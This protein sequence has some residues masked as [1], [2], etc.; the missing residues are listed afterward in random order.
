MIST[1]IE[2]VLI[3]VYKVLNFEKTTTTVIFIIYETFIFKMGP[4]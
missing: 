2:N 4:T 1:K 3:H